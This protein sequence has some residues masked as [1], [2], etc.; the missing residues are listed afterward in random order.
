LALEVGG[1]DVDSELAMLKASMLP[2]S[3]KPQAALGSGSN[4]V[5][6]PMPAEVDAELEALRREMDT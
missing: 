3:S 5:S 2:A 4:P 1:S 6:A